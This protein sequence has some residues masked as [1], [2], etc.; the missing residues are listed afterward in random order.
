MV[1]L[2]WRAWGM[3]MGRQHG[4]QPSTQRQS[5]CAPNAEAKTFCL[6]AARLEPRQTHEIL[7]NDGVTETS[8]A[9]AWAPSTPSSQLIMPMLTMLLPFMAAMSSSD[10]AWLKLLVLTSICAHKCNWSEIA[11]AGVQDG[12]DFSV[13]TLWTRRQCRGRRSP[14]RRQGR[15]RCPISSAPAPC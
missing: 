15:R 2:Q 6:C 7:V 11:W 9:K 10:A 3:D 12:L 13:P 8:S 14:S 4:R 5:D 1:G